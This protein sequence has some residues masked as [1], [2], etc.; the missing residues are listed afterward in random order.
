MR[1]YKV[2]ELRE[3]IMSEFDCVDDFPFLDTLMGTDGESESFDDFDDE[4]NQHDDDDMPY[5]DDDLV[6]AYLDEYDSIY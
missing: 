6:G 5:D 4:R 2:S 3:N 1:L